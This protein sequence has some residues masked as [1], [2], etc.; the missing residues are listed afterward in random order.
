MDGVGD[1]SDKSVGDQVSHGYC[2]SMVGRARVEQ[3]QS[4]WKFSTA[5]QVQ[6]GPLRMP[7]GKSTASLHLWPK[8]AEIE[9]VEITLAGWEIGVA[10]L[11]HCDSILL[12]SPSRETSMDMD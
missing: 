9:F 4:Y 12:T 3:Q 2:I 8:K 1:P 10:S 7:R 5:M 11:L 6:E